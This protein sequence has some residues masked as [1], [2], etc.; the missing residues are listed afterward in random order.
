[1]AEALEFVV[2]FLAVWIYGT[3]DRPKHPI[4][5]NGVRIVAF[6]GIIVSAA[7]FK[8]LLGSFEF[9]LIFTLVWGGCSL[10]V[11]SAEYYL[12]SKRICFAAFVAYPIWLAVAVSSQAS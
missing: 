8:G 1:M 10:V 12:G 4:W 6:S 7:G 9:P 2:T 5:R 3:E 11:I